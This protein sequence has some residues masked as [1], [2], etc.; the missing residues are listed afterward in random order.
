VKTTLLPIT[1]GGK[2]LPV[3]LQPPRFAAH[4]HELLAEL[5]YRDDEMAA[6]RASGAVA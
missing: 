2:R 6:L 5:G 3:R 1:L 4:S